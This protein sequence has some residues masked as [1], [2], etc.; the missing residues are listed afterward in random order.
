MNDDI[1]IQAESDGSITVHSS[2]DH[3]NGIQKLYSLVL[4]NDTLSIMPN[5]R[6]G[7][8]D[9][10]AEFYECDTMDKVCLVHGV[11][12]R[13]VII[14]RFFLAAIINIALVG[15]IFKVFLS[16]EIFD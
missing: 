11:W 7:L 13:S 2:M 3:R 5:F 12:N 9:S 16:Q 1:E 10:M 8:D 14:E 4:R 15:M 6:S